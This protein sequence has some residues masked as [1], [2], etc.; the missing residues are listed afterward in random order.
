[1]TVNT[2]LK[3]SE[4]NSM[5]IATVYNLKSFRKAILN[6]YFSIPSAAQP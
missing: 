6:L 3:S 2:D 5:R 4:L 1:M